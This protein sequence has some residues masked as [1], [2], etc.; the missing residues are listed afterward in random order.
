MS[1]DHSLPRNVFRVGAVHNITY[2]SCRVALTENLCDLAVSHHTTLWDLSDDLIYAFSI[3]LFI[4]KP[5]A[6]SLD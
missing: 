2:R 1:I 3:A 4:N 5:H 6:L